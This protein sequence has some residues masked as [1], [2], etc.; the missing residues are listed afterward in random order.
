MSVK[1]FI[2]SDLKFSIDFFPANFYVYEITGDFEKG[3]IEFRS[4]EVIDDYWGPYIT[5]EYSWEHVPFDERDSDGDL[6]NEI[7][8]HFSKIGLQ[9][10]DR[11]QK[12]IQSDYLQY[13]IGGRIKHVK[14]KAYAVIEIHGIWYDEIT[15]RVV[16]FNFSVLREIFD[17]WK[18]PLIQLIESVKFH[19]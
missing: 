11:I 2:N 4:E 6:I 10:I 15:E 1:N 5:F 8:V 7:D 9:R 19:I 14:N 13:L 17:D 16:N 3:N 18:N 12:Y